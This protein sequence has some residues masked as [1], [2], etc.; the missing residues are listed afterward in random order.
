MKKFLLLF[1][2]LVAAKNIF[3]H[4]IDYGKI[5]LKKWYVKNQNKTLEGSFYMY[6]DG[7]VYI[8]DAH[9]K[10]IPIPLNQLTEADQN[11]VYKK[12]SR[13]IQL[14]NE[15]SVKGKVNSKL[16]SHLNEKFWLILLLITCLFIYVLFFTKGS[17]RSYLIP[18]PTMGVFIFF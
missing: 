15:I 2:M 9:S 14:N 12:Y 16:S 3:A 6:K 8:E 5:I 18:I 13:V 1:L 11:F 7:Q 4:D 17:K 10:V